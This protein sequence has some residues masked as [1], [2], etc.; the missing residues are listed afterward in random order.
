MKFAEGRERVLLQEMESMERFHQRRSHSRCTCRCSWSV[1][2]LL[3]MMVVVMMTDT[4]P[5]LALDVNVAVLL[6]FDDSYMFSYRRVAPAI[7]KAISYLNSNETPLLWKHRLHVRYA[8]TKCNIA[9]G[10]D[11]AINFFIR[12]EVSSRALVSG[13]CSHIKI[14]H[15]LWLLWKG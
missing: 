10:M 2:N 6:P 11:R 14:P 8:D 9:A 13:F 5:S 12:R 7:E 1:M 4:R 15:P 3:L